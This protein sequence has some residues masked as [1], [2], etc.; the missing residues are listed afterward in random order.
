MSQLVVRIPFITMHRLVLASALEGEGVDGQEVQQEG[1]VDVGGAAEAVAL[2]APVA[3][4]VCMSLA[5]LT[6]LGSGTLCCGRI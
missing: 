1:L 4:G 6:I 5:R 2:A 3:A